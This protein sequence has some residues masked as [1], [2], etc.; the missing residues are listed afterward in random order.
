MK[1]VPGKVNL[2]IK[3]PFLHFESRR[4]NKCIK[5]MPPIHRNYFQSNNEM[6]HARAFVE[7]GTQ[8]ILV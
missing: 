7:I 6:F 2:R 1:K 4:E 3:L 5:K 8:N